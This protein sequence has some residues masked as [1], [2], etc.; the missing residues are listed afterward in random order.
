MRY[1]TCG[2]SSLLRF[3]NLIL[4]T[5]LL[6]HLILHKSFHYS[7]LRLHHLSIHRPFTPDLKLIRFTNRFLR[8]TFQLFTCVGLGLD[9]LGTG[10]CLF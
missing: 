3:V 7:P 1:I 9:L 4:F 6:I 10:V 2:I 8:R 5:L